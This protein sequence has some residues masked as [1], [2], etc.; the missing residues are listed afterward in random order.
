MTKATA[1]QRSETS[2]SISSSVCSPRATMMHSGETD[3]KKKKRG[4]GSAPKKT[5][6]QPFSTQFLPS[7]LQQAVGSWGFWVHASEA[8]I[9]TRFPPNVCQ[10]P[11][12]SHHDPEDL[13]YMYQKATFSPIFYPIPPQNPSASNG[14]TRILGACTKKPHFHP[15]FHPVPLQNPSTIIMIMRIWGKCSKKP[16]FH[17]FSTQFLPKPLL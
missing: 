2:S 14:I 7:T 3:K 12:K 15:F 6:F 5:C 9:F 13:G 17:P 8:H 11:F 16:H 1:V 10:K 4:R